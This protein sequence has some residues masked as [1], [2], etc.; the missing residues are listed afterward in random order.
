MVTQKLEQAV[1]SRKDFS[2]RY[3]MSHVAALKYFNRGRWMM[4]DGITYHSW[5]DGK[6]WFAEAE[7]ETG[8]EKITGNRPITPEA[9]KAQKTI[10]EIKLLRNRNEKM[11]EELMLDWS[12]ICYRTF[13]VFYGAVAGRIM[14][15]RIDKELAKKLDD[16]IKEETSTIEENL[17]AALEEY[18]NESR[19]RLR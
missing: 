12:R 4:P 3:N 11:R 15:L 17:N 2:E 13:S 6:R 18:E 14:G 8:N 19:G 1:I 16:I 9:L 7:T 5:Q 10:E